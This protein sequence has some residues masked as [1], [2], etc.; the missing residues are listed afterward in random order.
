[1]YIVVLFSVCIVKTIHPNTVHK[2][3][4]EDVHIAVSLIHRRLLK[5]PP[6]PTL[7]EHLW[8]GFHSSIFLGVRR[9]TK[10]MMMYLVERLNSATL[11]DL[12]GKSG[13]GFKSI[14][15]YM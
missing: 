14:F 3:C 13:A 15:M 1:M 7:R 9:D 4:F 5:L 10:K 2:K 8:Q 12:I 6:P 11:N